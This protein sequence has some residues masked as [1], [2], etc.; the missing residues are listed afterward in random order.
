MKDKKSPLLELL[1]ERKVWSYA[2]Y[3]GDPVWNERDKARQREAVLLHA[4]VNPSDPYA[5]A[6]MRLHLCKG[7]EDVSEVTKDAQRILRARQNRRMPT[8]ADHE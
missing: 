1:N 4:Q 2:P 5:A 6:R 7:F 3:P 8:N